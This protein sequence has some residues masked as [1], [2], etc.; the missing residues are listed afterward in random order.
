MG[1]VGYHIIVV[2]FGICVF[3]IERVR[4]RLYYHGGNRLTQRSH[5]TYISSLGSP[6]SKDSLAGPAFL[7][8][9]SQ[10][11]GLEHGRIAQR[12]LSSQKEMS[13][14]LQPLSSASTA[15]GTSVAELMAR[16]SRSITPQSHGE[17]PV[18]IPYTPQGNPLSTPAFPP[19]PRSQDLRHGTSHR[20]S[21][22]LLN[23]RVPTSRVNHLPLRSAYGFSIDE[24]RHQKS[25][26]N[27]LPGAK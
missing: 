6:N 1:C 14:V 3:M 23:Q 22:C 7:S 11:L 4:A 25:S 17:H 8:I 10:G 27:S 5:C 20:P 18:H 2:A 26:R 16:T 24:R 13:C 9:R 12:S 21:R 15:P 19:T